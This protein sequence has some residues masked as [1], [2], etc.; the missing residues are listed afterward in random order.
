MPA[1][2]TGIASR[3]ARGAPWADTALINP[4]KVR[5][6][7][8]GTLSAA[9]RAEFERMLAQQPDWLRRQ[10]DRID[11]GGEPVCLI[12]T[13]RLPSV[14]AAQAMAAAHCVLAVVAPELPS[15]ASARH[16]PIPPAEKSFAWVLNRFD[17]RYRLNQDLR[18]LMN[19]HLP[20]DA[21]MFVVHRDE[22]LPEAQA[23]DQ[24]LA[25]YA[26]HCQ[27]MFDLQVIDAWLRALQR[28]EAVPAA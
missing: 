12:D 10:L 27:A 3:A 9:D 28:G 2:V 5:L 25:E 22:S 26:P 14:Y 23:A 4:Q 8:H 15:L 11:L 17:P 13:A 19:A 20:G 16:F 1:P 7:P 24:P 18:A 6:L 21:P